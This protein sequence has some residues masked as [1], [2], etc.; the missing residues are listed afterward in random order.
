MKT[1]DD[2]I[3]RILDPIAKTI[4]LSVVLF[5]LIC[6]L[7]NCSTPPQTTID[8]QSK[9]EQTEIAIDKG[10][11]GCK[12]LECADAMKRSKEY[13]RESLDTVKSRDTQIVGLNNL[14]KASEIKIASLQEKITDLET[15]VEPWRTIKR[16]FWI[17][18]ISLVVGYL[19]YVFRSTLWTLIKA[20]LKIA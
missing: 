8:L 15:E 18:I 13:I 14:L 20:A 1:F 5:V 9:A 16:W 3:N 6:W 17:T 4:L 2:A 12:S 19:V 7:F 11:T 10:E